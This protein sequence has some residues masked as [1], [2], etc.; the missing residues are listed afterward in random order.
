MG[1][2][3]QAGR[4]MEQGKTNQSDAQLL[5]CQ[6]QSA[7]WL[8]LQN[9][10]LALENQPGYCLWADGNV[11]KIYNNCD[12]P[13]SNEDLLWMRITNTL[14]HQKSGGCL[15]V[16]NDNTDQKPWLVIQECKVR[17]R[18]TQIWHFT[19]NI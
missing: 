11:V 9:G 5:P 15:D 14:V 16:M 3:Q 2:L 10:Q 4:C 8:L 13:S 19:V 17:E 6:L 7:E 18:P 12:D 1:Q